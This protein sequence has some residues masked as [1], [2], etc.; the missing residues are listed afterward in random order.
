MSS[1]TTD[2]IVRHAT[3][4]ARDGDQVAAADQLIAAADRERGPLE[5]ARDQVA[6]HLHRHVDDFDATGALRL[7]N[8][9]LSRLPVVDP[10]DWRVRWARHRKP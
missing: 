5:A 1:T 7:L 3:D 6:T 2:V 8:R 9:A 10:L 4:L